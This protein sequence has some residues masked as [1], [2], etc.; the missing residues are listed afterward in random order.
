[1]ALLTDPGRVLTVKTYKRWD[2]NP[3]RVWVNTYEFVHQTAATLASI[4]DLV[5][6][7]SIAEASFHYNKVEYD[8]AVVSTWVQDNLVEQAFSFKTINLEGLKGAKT[9]ISTGV[10]DLRN[11]MQVNFNAST[12]RA[13]RRLYRGALQESDVAAANSGL[14]GTLEPALQTAV[15]NAFANMISRT[16]LFSGWIPCLFTVLAGDSATQLREIEGVS[17]K[18]ATTRQLRRG[19]SNSG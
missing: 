8:R 1:M 19:T 15:V 10:L 9:P 2:T 12:G 16:G 14:W 13:G 17:V 4:D 11:V 5:T 3:D 18:G 6:G 7:I